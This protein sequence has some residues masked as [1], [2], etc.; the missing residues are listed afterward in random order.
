MTEK[1]L[2][3]FEKEFGF[4]LLPTGLKSL[5]QKSQKRNTEN[6]LNT[7]TTQLLMIIQ[8]RRMIFNGRVCSNVTK[9]I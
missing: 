1:D 2:D 4:K 5:Y 3:E 6:V 7:Y 8:M 9:N